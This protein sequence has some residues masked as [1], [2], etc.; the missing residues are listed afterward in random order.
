[1]F[2]D[3]GSEGAELRAAERFYRRALDR[4][5]AFVEARIHLGRVLG[6]RGRHADAAREL[7]QALTRTD[8]ALLLYYGN[9]FLGAE[10]EALDRMAEAQRAYSRAAE[11]FPAAQSSRLALSALASRAGDRAAALRLVEPVLNR[12]E[13]GPADDPWWSYRTSHT[14]ALDTLVAEL[15]RRVA[16][17]DRP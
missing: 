14:R 11:L 2:F 13:V 1:V 10:E 9:M 4:N 16:E 17:L 8:D 15:Y 7:R 3:V 5:P 6:R 12:V